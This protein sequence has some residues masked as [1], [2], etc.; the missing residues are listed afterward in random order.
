MLVGMRR[1]RGRSFMPVLSWR[2]GRRRVL[3]L[4]VGRRW[5]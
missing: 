4:L 3:M 1:G 5:G 2:R